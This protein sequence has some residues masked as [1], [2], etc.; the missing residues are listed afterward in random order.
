MKKYILNGFNNLYI[1]TYLRYLKCKFSF[2][3]YHVEFPTNVVRLP[4]FNK[5]YDDAYNEETL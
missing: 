4:S 2:F 5:I 1:L 3:W